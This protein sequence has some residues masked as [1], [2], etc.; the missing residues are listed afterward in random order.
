MRILTCFL[1]AV[2]MTSVPSLAQIEMDTDS[3]E[4]RYIS[5]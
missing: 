5:Q 1:S 2:F 3:N 4:E